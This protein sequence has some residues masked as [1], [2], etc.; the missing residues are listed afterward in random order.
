M[1]EKE[2]L[3]IGDR[4]RISEIITELDDEYGFCGLNDEMRSR[5]G[6]IVTIRKINDN[7]VKIEED[8]GENFGRDGYNWEYDYLEF[9]A[10]Q[11]LLSE[12]IM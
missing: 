10:P 2:N 1:M 7:S 8:I 4:V 9:V 12:Y 6:T 5:A 11:V 3:K